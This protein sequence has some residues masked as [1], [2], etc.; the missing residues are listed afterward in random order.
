[1]IRIMYLF[2]AFAT[3]AAMSQEGSRIQLNGK[4]TADVSVPEGVYVINKKTE[5]TSITGQDGNFSIMAAVGDTLLFSAVQF[6][7]TKI[8]L[9]Q[10]HF[11]QGI[12]FE[13][14]TPIAN[15]L[16]EVIVRNGINAVSMGIIPREQKI[17][18]PAERKL[19]TAS[20][21]NASANVGSMMGGSVSADPLLNWISGRT[22][23]LKKELEV[24][25]KESYLRQLENLFAVDYFV[26]KLKIPVEYVKGFE[27][28]SLENERFVAVLKS[29]NVTM[30]TFLMGELAI[31]Y[32]E[33]IASEN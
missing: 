27:Y 11:D 19:Y 28:Y 6:K 16:R 2:L 17:Y 31:K 32:K 25:Q 10:V 26:S 33:I 13:K 3:T 14:M 23:M 9:T 12:L 18:T 21:L 4:V 20:N 22:K 15:Q 29:K 1:M 5:K 30:T 7:D 24:E 8:L